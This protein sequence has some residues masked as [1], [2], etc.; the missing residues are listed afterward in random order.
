MLP[1]SKYK[2]CSRER[3]EYT[4]FMGEIKINLLT[5]YFFTTEIKQRANF[6]SSTRFCF[7]NFL[8]FS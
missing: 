2:A 7:G 3:H 4:A 1:M 8:E 6:V 5:C